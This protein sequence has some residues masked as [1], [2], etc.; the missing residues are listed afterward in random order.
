MIALDKK[1]VDEFTELAVKTKEYPNDY[2]EMRK[3]RI[4]LQNL[5]GITEIE[6]FNVLIK[7]NIMDYISKYNRCEIGGYI[8][9]KHYHLSKKKEL[10]Q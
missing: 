4:E 2:G 7:K 9:Q 5:C 10:L 6:A 3:L 8:T 1:I